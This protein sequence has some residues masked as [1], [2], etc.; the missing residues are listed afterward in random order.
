MV[1]LRQ[2]RSLIVGILVVAIV[3]AYVLGDI[4]DAAAILAVLAANI[5]IGFALELKAHRAIESLLGLEVTR[6]RVVREGTVRELDARDL[7]PGNIIEIEAGVAIPADA[8][9]LDSTELRTV[10]ASLTGEA[11]PVDKVSDAPVAR[12]IPLLVG[13]PCYTKRP[14]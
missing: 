12:D 11:V 6:A 8:R 2:L 4:L 14:R 13:S 1:F 5:L 9:I 7:V 10:E 3:I